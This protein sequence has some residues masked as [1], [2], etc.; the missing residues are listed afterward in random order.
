MPIETAN[1]YIEIISKRRLQEAWVIH[2]FNC[3]AIISV[4]M[5][6][7][8]FSLNTGK[9]KFPCLPFAIEWPNVCGSFSTDVNIY[10]CSIKLEDEW[11]KR[12][13]RLHSHR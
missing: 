4:R 5:N 13:Q 12:K 6:F 11:K 7:D 2:K 1:I 3:I 9:I 8:F 10:L